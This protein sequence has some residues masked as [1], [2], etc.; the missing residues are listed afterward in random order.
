MSKQP[1]DDGNAAIPVLSYR[2][3]RGQAVTYTTA[4]ARSAQFSDS[5]RVVSIYATDSCFIELG[6]SNVTANT[7]NSHFIPAGVYMDISLG[8]D[9]DSR[10]SY[11][12]L[13]VISEFNEGTLYISERE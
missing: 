6:D 4:P 10:L 8:S 12:Y 1:R 11:K 13:S 2:P 5:V 7:S 3:Q 9:N